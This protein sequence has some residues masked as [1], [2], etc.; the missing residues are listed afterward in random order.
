MHCVHLILLH[1]G[2]Y[3][4]QGCLFCTRVYILQRGVILHRGVYSVQ[5][6]IFC[7]GVYI[8]GCLFFQG[9]YSAQGCIFCT[10]V[11]ILHRS[12]Y[13][14][15]GCIFFQGVYSA[16]GCLF[17]QSIYAAQGSLFC[18]QSSVKAGRAF[19]LLPMC[20]NCWGRE[21]GQE[22]CTTYPS[23]YRRTL[24]TFISYRCKNVQNIKQSQVT[25]PGGQVCSAASS[26]VYDTMI[27]LS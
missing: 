26:H 21:F 17:C 15:Q 19:T 20:N 11:Y 23:L 3:S 27:G 9:V 2:V 18:T 6:C 13:S 22:P 8:L 25:E 14:A 24:S 7:A 16:S 1:R 10:G 4:A 12:V 5:G